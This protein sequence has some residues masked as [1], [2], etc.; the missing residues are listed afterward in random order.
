MLYFNTILG[1]TLSRSP[2][3]KA[4]NISLAEWAG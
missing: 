1:A 4:S 2:S 3:L